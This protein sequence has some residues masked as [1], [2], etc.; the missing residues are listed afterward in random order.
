MLNY[1][2][3]MLIVFNDLMTKW[4]MRCV[5][6]SLQQLIIAHLLCTIIHI[7][8]NVSFIVVKDYNTIMI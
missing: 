6:F 8:H 7:I 3:K 1:T 2:A 4:T 5:L